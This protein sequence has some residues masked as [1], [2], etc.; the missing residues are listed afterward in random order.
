MML[1]LTCSQQK[2]SKQCAKKPGATETEVKKILIGL[3]G[4]CWLLGLSTVQAGPWEQAE[5]S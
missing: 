1:S 5:K 2:H 4:M 3:L